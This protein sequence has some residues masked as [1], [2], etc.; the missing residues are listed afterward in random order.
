ME[1][2]GSITSIPWLILKKPTQV[3]R[4]HLDG[5]FDQQ[6]DSEHPQKSRTVMTP[7]AA[8][9]VS[10]PI[11][12]SSALRK[13]GSTP[14]GW[15]FGAGRVAAQSGRRCS[16]RANDQLANRV[17]AVRGTVSKSFNLSIAS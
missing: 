3:A 6:T 4:T 11:F 15:F 10:F 12:V 9:M 14:P 8:V 13:T 5:E 1:A 7:A 2:A 16:S 17:S